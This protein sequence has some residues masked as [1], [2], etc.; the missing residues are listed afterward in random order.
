MRSKKKKTPASSRAYE[1]YLMTTKL[2]CGSCGAMMVGT[3]GTSKT[4]KVY[5][6]Y[7]CKGVINK[8]GCKKKNVHKSFIEDFVIAKALEQLTD[9][10]INLIAKAVSEIS[11]AENNSHIIIDLKRQ[12]RENAAALENLLKAI[13]S[14]QHIELL[15]SRITKNEEKK[16]TLEKMLAL[17]Q[18][19]KTSIDENEVKFFLHQ[20]KKG[21]IRDIAYKRAL[22][23]VFINKVYL[24]DDRVR[25]IF[26]ASDRP[27]E[28]DYE[29]LE[30]IAVLENGGIIKGGRCSYL[31]ECTTGGKT[32]VIRVI[33][34]VF[35]LQDK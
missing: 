5:H 6:Y 12:L 8:K 22:I 11:K 34:R 33:A 31:M 29:L 13:E 28:I 24:Y 32:L 1:E 2:F 16:S 9:D 19:N 15:S 25:I 4:G 10:N 30:E 27:V 3:G 17:E 20:L 18:M 26:N 23:S 21:Y 7:G 14:G 35:C